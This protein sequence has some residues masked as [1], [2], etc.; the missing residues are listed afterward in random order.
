[1]DL[2]PCLKL[3]VAFQKSLT[4]QGRACLKLLTLYLQARDH[5]FML[6]SALLD[7]QGGGDLLLA[8]ADGNVKTHSAFLSCLS[9][10]LFNLLATVSSCRETNVIYFDESSYAALRAIL[11]L[12][13]NGEVNIPLNTVSE[14]YDLAIVFGLNVSVEQKQSGRRL[15]ENVVNFGDSC[16]GSDVGVRTPIAERGGVVEEDCQRIW[17]TSVESGI[18]RK[19]NSPSGKERKGPCA[20]R[21][22]AKQSEGMD[23]NI[24]QFEETDWE[25]VVS[26]DQDDKCRE[27]IKANTRVKERN[28]V[29]GLCGFAETKFGQ[30]M[31]HIGSHYKA[32][33]RREY[34]KGEDNTCSICGKVFSKSGCLF[35]H[36][37]IFHRVALDYYM[38]EMELTEAQSASSEMNSSKDRHS[39]KVC[40]GRMGEINGNNTD[41]TDEEFSDHCGHDEDAKVA[42]ATGDD[43]V[44]FLRNSLSE[45]S[46]AKQE[47]GNTNDEDEGGDPEEPD[48]GEGEEDEVDGS[49]GEVPYN[50]G[51]CGEGFESEKRF[52]AHLASKHYKARL[53]KEFGNNVKTC[54]ICSSTYARSKSISR[55][56]CLAFAFIK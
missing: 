48:E 34:M 30:M 47:G 52:M 21:L 36:V 38:E 44:S 54:P 19:M 22:T 41:E 4:F 40:A 9:P 28:N 23:E 51:A 20:A 1:M 39:L 43:E 25:E 56:P 6:R 13:Y 31:A 8:A 26:V 27:T 16:N 37:T 45:K 35:R 46:D 3:E 5:T 33:I 49:Y 11:H 42:R 2:S 17:R 12:I 50:C 53:R 24:N 10:K 18:H 14:A 32:R 29:C 55:S 7:Q 15:E